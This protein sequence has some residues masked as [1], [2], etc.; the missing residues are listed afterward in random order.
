MS[1]NYIIMHK[2]D[3]ATQCI[4][5]SARITVVQ[6]PKDS[7][8]YA[9]LRCG[10]CDLFKGWKA[11]PESEGK[12]RDLAVRINKALLAPGLTQWEKEFCISLKKQKKLSP[13]QAEALSRI[14]AKV[15]GAV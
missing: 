4:C 14:K 13:R 2:N 10:Q 6:M 9:A 15:G 3:D 1:G 5:G 11:K 8:H 12:R 7:T